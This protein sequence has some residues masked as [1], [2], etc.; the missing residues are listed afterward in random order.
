LLAL[1]KNKRKAGRVSYNNHT[2]KIENRFIPNNFILTKTC[3]VID[4]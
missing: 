2:R 4:A 3:K 1:I